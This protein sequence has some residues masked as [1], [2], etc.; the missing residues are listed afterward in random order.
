MYAYKKEVTLRY[1]E[2]VKRL[3]EELAVE[4][5]GVI[6]EV[7]V[8]ETLKKKLGVNYSRYIILGACN[9]GFAYKALQA[10]KDVGLLLP[11]NLVVYEEEGKTFI[12]ALLPSVAM[13][14]IDN[15][16]LKEIAEIVESKLKKVV[17]SVK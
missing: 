9:P 15:S 11:C 16:S 14:M 12:A 3:R 1:Q 4:G 5:F 6:T 10:E 7:D 8:K 13:S 2:A 17:D